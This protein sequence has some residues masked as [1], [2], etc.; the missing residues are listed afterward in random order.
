MRWPWV[1]V[2]ALAS[3]SAWAEDCGKKSAPLADK[4]ACERRN[5]AQA[6]ERMNAAYDH[7]L[8]IAA[9][10]LAQ[11]GLNLT[12]TITATQYN[13]S[14]WVQDQC[15]L[16]SGAF[17]SGAGQLEEARCRQAKIQERSVSLNALAAKLDI[18]AG[19]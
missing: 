8:G 6:E 15:L 19:H 2:A 16:E 13:W 7:V 11:S 4:T 18:L 3:T 17:I 12:A 9:G 5:V 1:L 14:K 10:L